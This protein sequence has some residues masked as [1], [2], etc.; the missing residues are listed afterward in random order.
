MRQ[1]GNQTLPTIIWIWHAQSLSLLKFGIQNQKTSFLPVILP[2]NRTI[3][4]TF[5]IHLVEQYQLYLQQSILQPSMTSTNEVHIWTMTNSKKSYWLLCQP[6]HKSA[7]QEHCPEILALLLCWLH[8]V[9][10]TSLSVHCWHRHIITFVFLKT[11]LWYLWTSHHARNAGYLHPQI[12]DW[13]SVGPMGINQC[14][15][16]TTTSRS[17][18]KH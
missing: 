3:Q 10:C 11:I 18:D 13:I 15:C 5:P 17:D 12:L 7:N 16:S 6:N 4:F 9:V 1:P 2:Q 8:Q 14:H